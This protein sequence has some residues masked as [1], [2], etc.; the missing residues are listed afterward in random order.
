MDI[1]NGR[2]LISFKISSFLKK[3]FSSTLWGKKY[4]L[5]CPRISCSL[6]NDKNHFRLAGKGLAV[7]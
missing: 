1:K 6:A 5:I 7:L 3:I 4:K 2:D